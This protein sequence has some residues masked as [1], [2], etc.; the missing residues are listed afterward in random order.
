M[1]RRRYERFSWEID[2]FDPARFAKEKAEAKRQGWTNVEWINGYTVGTPPP[3]PWNRWLT[4]RQVFHMPEG[5]MDLCLPNPK[6]TS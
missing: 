1:K 3:T 6:E 4:E 2:A 5:Q